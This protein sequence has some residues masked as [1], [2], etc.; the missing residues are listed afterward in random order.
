MVGIVVKVGNAQP[1]FI[2]NGN[3][4]KGIS[5]AQIP[6]AGPGCSPPTPSTSAAIG[7]YVSGAVVYGPCGVALVSH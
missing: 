2:A 1:F 5:A 4:V 6:R 3:R 7:R